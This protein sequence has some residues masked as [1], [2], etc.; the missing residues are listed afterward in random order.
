MNGPCPQRFVLRQTRKFT[1]LERFEVAVR[2]REALFCLRMKRAA[3]AARRALAA[4][5]PGSRFA[6]APVV[7]A[8][9]ARRGLDARAA[10]GIVGVVDGALDVASCAALRARLLRR[11]L[12]GHDPRVRADRVDFLPLHRGD[13]AL[14]DEFER[15]RTLLCGVAAALEPATALLVPPA[16]QLAVYDGGGYAP[17][18]DNGPVPGAPG[19]NYRALT[20]I[21]YLDERPRGGVGGELRCHLGDRAVDIAPKPG[22]LC[23]FKSRQVLHEVVPVSGWTR[24]ALTTWLLRDGPPP[25]L[26]ECSRL[27]ADP[28]LH[29]VFR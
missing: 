12:E 7:V 22:R 11:P 1:I 10:H 16:A 20:C 18:R 24:V 26:E 6:P 19:E 9:L 28:A 17:H 14:G 25:R 27:L 21:L 5:L 8:A 2:A 29:H 23:L 15:A 13:A 4:C 3:D